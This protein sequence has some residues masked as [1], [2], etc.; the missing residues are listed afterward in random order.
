[1]TPPQNN[2][3]NVARK[4][5]IQHMIVGFRPHEAS[6]IGGIGLH[7]LKRG[8]SQQLDQLH[9]LAFCHFGLHVKIDLIFSP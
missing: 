4:M 3:N 7:H 6:Q 8:S 2:H 1:M 5:A 9:V